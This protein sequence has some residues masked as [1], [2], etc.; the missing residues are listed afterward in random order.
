M[1]FAFGYNSRIRFA[2]TQASILG[3][4]RPVVGAMRPL[5]AQLSKHMLPFFHKKSQLFSAEDSTIRLT[6]YKPINGIQNILIKGKLGQ[7][8]MRIRT[9]GP[10]PLAQP[11]RSR[12]P[13]GARTETLY[14]AQLVGPYTPGEDLYRASCARDA[15]ET[16]AVNACVTPTK[17]FPSDKNRRE[18][19]DYDLCPSLHS[20]GIPLSLGRAGDTDL[21]GKNPIEIPFIKSNG[22][23]LKR[24]EL[25]RSLH[26]SK[27]L[28][29]PRIFH[30]SKV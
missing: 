21:K 28:E 13:H 14:E 27:T 25:Y 3:T 11:S 7:C 20:P 6:I 5:Q 9:L 4:P 19:N 24:P 18:V 8:K 26:K 2:P 1:T 17:H 23:L 16:T 22:L 30:G 10:R 15:L 29:G 12:I